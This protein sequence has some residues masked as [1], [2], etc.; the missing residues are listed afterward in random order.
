MVATICPPF[1]VG[2]ETGHLLPAMIAVMSA[3]FVGF[4]DHEAPAR[5]TFPIL[6][7]TALVVS[8]CIALGR[9]V[10][11]Y[12][13]DMLVLSFA[14]PLAAGLMALWGEAFAA[15]GFFGCVSYVIAMSVPAPPESIPFTLLWS[16]AGGI[17]AVLISLLP[18]PRHCVPLVVSKGPGAVLHAIRLSLAVG[19]ATIAAYG[20]NLERAYWVPMTAAF[21]MRPLI[22]HTRKAMMERCIGTAVGSIVASL[23]L[24]HFAADLPRIAALAAATFFTFTIFPVSYSGFSAR[25]A[26]VVLIELSIGLPP[27]PHVAL[28]RIEDTVL[29][30]GVAFLVHTLVVDRR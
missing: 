9:V 14:L 20:L 19:L 11:P 29:G 28:V 13:E 3:L 26:C 27:Y 24:G 7:L 25:I 2:Y 5:R 8:P 17:Y 18:W 22:F 10:P 16:L 12:L 1:V 30:A 15:A 23:I 21:V 6:L 4:S